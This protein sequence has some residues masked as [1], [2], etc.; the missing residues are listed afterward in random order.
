MVTVLA[1]L[2]G[3]AAGAPVGWFFAVRSVPHMLARM[4]ESEMDALADRVGELR[5]GSS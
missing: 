3:L 1:A 5:D 4:G 2:A